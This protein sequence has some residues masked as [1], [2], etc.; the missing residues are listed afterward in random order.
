MPKNR[1]Q[2]VYNRVRREDGHDVADQL[3]K[4]VTAEYRRKVEYDVARK[5]AR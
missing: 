1:R 2:E 3:V 5:A 4:D